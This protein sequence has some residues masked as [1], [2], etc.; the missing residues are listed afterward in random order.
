L[1]HV[2]AAGDLILSLGTRS[3]L[4]EL[5]SHLNNLGGKISVSF[6]QFRIDGLQNA[7]QDGTF[8]IL[9][10]PFKVFCPTQVEKYHCLPKF[11]FR[12][13]ERYLLWKFLSKQLR[14]VKSGDMLIL[15]GCLG[16]L[17]LHPK[18]LSRTI[19]WW[20]KLGII[21]EESQNLIR[22]HLRKWVERLN[23]KRFG[24]RLVVSNNMRQFLEREYG[25][26]KQGHF[27]LPCLVDTNKFSKH[28]DRN[29]LRRSLG[30]EKRF[31]LLYLGT[32]APWQ[33]VQETVAFFKR[34]QHHF[35]QAFL[36]VLT[37]DHQNFQRY[38]KSVQKEDY[39]IEFHRHERLGELM[40]AADMG[41]LL[42][43]RLIANRVSSPLKFPEYLACGLPIIIGPEV[44]DYSAIVE[45][46]RLGA[47][48][49]PE[50]P[51]HW[52]SAIRH[53]YDL[54]EHPDDIRK[55][56]LDKAIT[57]SW[58]AYEQFLRNE[59]TEDKC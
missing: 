44:G 38:L 54:M 57:L 12:L 58:G 46:E 13:H 10:F 2:I 24:R 8:S 9:D 23:S 17:H 37:P 40:P 14:S 30:F 15:H 48:V 6:F 11:I 55:R 16:I 3:Y 19:K 26:S 49:D 21:E 22:F 35:P 59:F 43:R 53:I 51:S 29:M 32:T 28:V 47:V 39:R 34:F 5:L 52:D 56:C 42:R 27:I 1:I 45:R 50:N 4:R 25:K 18:G 41:L 20:L 7:S 33:C 36:W 31:V